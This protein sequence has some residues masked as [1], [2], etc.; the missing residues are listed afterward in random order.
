VA[1]SLDKGHGRIE[2]RAPRTTP[3]LTVGP[4]W[5]G[6]KQGFEVTRGRT[7]RGVT[8]AGVV[9]GITGL[10]AGRANAAALLVI[11]RDHWGIENGP[12]YVRDVTLG[13]DGC[14]VRSGSAPQVLAAPRNAVVHLLAGVE[15]KSRPEAIERLQIDPEAAKKLIGIPQS[16]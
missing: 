7:I 4:K 14:R 16:E 11:L 9:Y 15:A 2:R 5:Q 12:H 3:I 10:A 8:T 6:L 13:E 1:A